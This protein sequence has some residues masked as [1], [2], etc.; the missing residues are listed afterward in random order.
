LFLSNCHDI[1]AWFHWLPAHR[2]S[3][4]MRPACWK[5]KR[6]KKSVVQIYTKNSH[7]KWL[8]KMVIH[9]NWLIHQKKF[10]LGFILRFLKNTPKI[11]SASVF[12]VFFFENYKISASNER[13][14]S[15]GFVK[16]IGTTKFHFKILTERT[17]TSVATK[18]KM[19]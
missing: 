14:G 6:L 1:Q 15:F 12:S 3:P 19:L 16:K 8:V 9:Q 17:L 13:N 5:N 4:G 11:I 10:Y 2:A 18:I 7:Q